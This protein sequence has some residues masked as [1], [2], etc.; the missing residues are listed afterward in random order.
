MTDDLHGKTCGVSEKGRESD[1]VVA[2]RAS[3][4]IC[5]PD[6]LGQ[7]GTT[8][9]CWGLGWSLF[10][11]G[12]Q[13]RPRLEAVGHSIVTTTFDVQKDTNCSTILKGTD[14]FVF[15]PGHYLTL[16]KEDN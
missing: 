16:E 8:E 5:F 6:V 10:R 2:G 3:S 12:T 14:H 11:A 9:L 13:N 4:G 1:L 15:H 7:S